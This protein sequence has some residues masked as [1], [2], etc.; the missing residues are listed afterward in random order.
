MYKEMPINI[1]NIVQ[2]IGNMIL[3]GVKLG[4]TKVGYQA[5]I[6]KEFKTLPKYPANRHKIKLN[7]NFL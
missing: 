2:T 6:E 3:A 4:L 7:D 1:Y 5:F